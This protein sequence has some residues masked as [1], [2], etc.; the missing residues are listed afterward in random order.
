MWMDWTYLLI[1]P[2]L[3]LAIWASSLVRSTYARYAKVPARAGVTAA[4]VAEKMLR[5]GGAY[6]VRVERTRGEL[7]DHYDPRDQV[8]RLSEGVYDSTSVAALGIA[9]HEAG[10]ALQHQDE[11]APL[12]LRTA[13]VPVVS[14][15]SNLATPLFLL[16]FVFSWQPLI[17]I[18]ILCFAAAVAFSLITLPVEFNASRRAVLALEGGGYL[19]AEENEG[20]RKVLRAASMTYVASAL[21]AILQLARLLL[22]SR[23]SNRRRN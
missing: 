8:L 19:T 1:L 13:I 7:T 14:I 10:H 2:G 4:E 15:T 3:L 23:G 18:G 20:A 16:G 21:T 17:Y 11:Y 9:A 6:G 12:W 22:L 5:E